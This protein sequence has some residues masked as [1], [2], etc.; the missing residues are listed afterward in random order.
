[1]LKDLQLLYSISQSQ[2]CFLYILLLLPAMP[3]F[4]SSLNCSDAEVSLIVPDFAS[5]VLWKCTS[6]EQNPRPL[7][8]NAKIFTT[9][10]QWRLV[11][12]MFWV[13]IST[14][15]SRSRGFL[16]LWPYIFSLLFFLYLHVCLDI[17][18]CI[19]LNRNRKQQSEKEIEKERIT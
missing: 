9:R 13:G 17:L 10:P 1:M 2:V 18:S 19:G 15:Y 6:G 12:W 14:V 4:L 8:P 5:S 3:F 16:L 7:Y 11:I